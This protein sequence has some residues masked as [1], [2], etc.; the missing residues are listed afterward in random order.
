MKVKSLL[1]SMCAIAAL[2][3]CSQ[4]DD[5]APTG[6]DAPKAQVILKLEGDGV[7]TRVAGE[8]ETATEDGAAIKN[9]T[10]FF[11]NQ[12]G[13]IVGAPKFIVAADINNPITTTTDAAEVVVIANLGDKTGDG[14][15]DGI[16]SLSQLQKLDFSSINTTGTAPDLTYTV[17]QSK[18][19]LYSSGMGA[20]TF[21][22]NTGTASVQLHFVAAKIKTVKIAWTAN[23]NYAATESDLTSD[24]SKWFTIRKVYMMTAQTKSPLIPANTVDASWGGFVPQTYA[25][26]GGVS[27]GT[28]PWQWTG[29]NA[30]KQTDDYLAVAADL[31]ES[32]A[33]ANQIDNALASKSWYLFENSPASTHPTGLV[34]EVVW[35]SKDQSTDAS[36][37]LTKYFT[38][39]FGEAGANGT[40]QPL[41]T[42]G[43]TYDMALSLKGDFKPGGNA[44][45]GGDDPTKPSV[46]ASVTVTVTAAHW[47]TTDEITKDFQ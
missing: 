8:A 39:Y 15:F 42:A 38:M 7:N 26:A 12:T 18:A 41:L 40:T 46:D 14:T 33:N 28:A 4:N 11:F 22:D 1:L 44:G 30:P 47:T 35:R 32:T 3:S 29:D 20:V 24:V 45:G 23:Q 34:I 10:V 31:V 16:A 6:S 9:V 25:F 43:K 27:W 19:N 13:F 21:T 2:A 17:N 37:L 5:V 36:D